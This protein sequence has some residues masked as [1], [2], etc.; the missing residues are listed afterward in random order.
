[1]Y[2]IKFLIFLRVEARKG[3]A[4]FT[5]W[6]YEVVSRAKDEYFDFINKFLDMLEPKFGELKELGVTRDDI[7]IWFL[8]NYDQQCNIE[9]DSQR[10]K[11]LGESGVTLCISCWEK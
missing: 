3:S 5:R 8:Y 6:S 2:I 7:S 4:T 11:R 9:F 10:M 1:M